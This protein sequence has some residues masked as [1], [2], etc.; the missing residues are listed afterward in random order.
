MIP[1]EVD[2][3]NAGGP[4]SKVPPGAA[5]LRSPRLAATLRLQRDPPFVLGSESPTLRFLNH[6][7][8]FSTFLSVFSVTKT[9]RALNFEITQ[10]CLT[11]VG[12][13][14]PFQMD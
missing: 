12:T 1:P 4:R 5:A 14:G 9:L 10:S 7:R 6:F 11:H 13:E 3:A 2:D 8:I